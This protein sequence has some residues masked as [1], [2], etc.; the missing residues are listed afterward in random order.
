MKSTSHLKNIKFFTLL[1]VCIGLSAQDSFIEEV[2]V[3][4]EK[5]SESL[6]DISQAVTAISDE[7]IENKNITSFVDLSAIV[8]GVTVAKNEGYKTVI[9][10]RGVG[11]ET[12]QNAIAA[13]SVAFHMDGIFIA[14]PFSL[15]TDF[16]DVDRIE[17]LRGPQGTLFGQNSTGGAINVISKK[18]IFDE[19]SGK[20]DLSFG[21]YGLVK[22]RSSNNIPLSSSSAARFA[23][24]VTERDGFSKNVFTGQELDDASNLSFRTDLLFELSDTSSLRLFAQYFDVDRNGSA[25]RGIDDPTPDLRKLSQDTVS[26]HELTS[27]IIAGI[28]EADLGS[29]TLKMMASIQEDDILVVRDNDRHNFGDPVLSIPGL[30]SGAVYQRA[31][32]NPETSLVDTTTFEINLISNE[33]AMGGKLDWTIGAFYMEHEIENVIR[34][35]RDNDLTGQLRYLCSESFASSDYCYTHDFGIPGRFDVFG[36]DW[37]FVTD[38]FPSRESYSVY[39]QITYSLSE[40]SRLISGLRYSEDTF[41]TDVTNFFNV[42]S[43][44]EKGTNDETTWKLTG[45]RDLSDSSMA[46]LSFTRGFKPGGSNLTFG[47]TEAQD[48]EAGRPV[49]PALVFPTF[50]AETV[51]SIEIGLKAD[52]NEGRTR[53]NLAYFTYT[54]DNLQFQATDPDPYR[55]GVA[56]IPES[57]MSGLEVELKSLVSD[58]LTFDMNLAFLDSEVTSDYMV[59]DN[60]DAYQYFFG[61]EDLRYGL[62]ENVKGNELAKSPEFTA[63]VNFTYETSLSSGTLVTSIFQFIHRGD[64]QQRVSNNPAVDA[65]D[66]YDLINLTLGFDFVGD[67]W[68]LDFMILNATDEDGV[69]SSMTDVF[70]VAATG[71]ELIPPRQ[72]MLRLSMNY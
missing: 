7:D 26:K 57:E 72:Y 10:I 23:I 15:Q 41:T 59:L 43:F 50:E 52:L 58:S 3:T 30:G 25:M 31:E 17:V 61:Q 42:E 32:F 65:I 19:K 20:Y 62:R 38:A 54:Y 48:L 4:A 6:Q 14:S 18:P 35:Y 66:S 39:G 47:F 11:N 46:Y 64:F 71:L 63:D 27:S 69:N 13:P 53:A 8:P 37:D 40:T 28:Y 36:A 5:R 56:N 29:A 24:S 49:A 34:G 22:F 33:P 55:G 9:S 70:G 12:N 45:E 51:D 2:F 21:N 68:G 67:K 16:I 60:V 44:Q 1:F